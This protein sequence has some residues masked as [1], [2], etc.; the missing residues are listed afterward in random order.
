MCEVGGAFFFYKSDQK[1]GQ[2]QEFK[3]EIDLTSL[4]KIVTHYHSN[5][6]NDILHVYCR[7]DLA[8]G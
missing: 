8:P 2:T 4:M 1:G 6:Q 3:F 5:K 7:Q